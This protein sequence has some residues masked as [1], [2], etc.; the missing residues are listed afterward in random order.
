[1]GLYQLRQE[2]G[3]NK[4]LTIFRKSVKVIMS[5]EEILSLKPRRGIDI[6]FTPI[7]TNSNIYIAT[8]SGTDLNPS[9]PLEEC[10]LGDL[11]EI[12]AD[13][14][15]VY[16]DRVREPKE[17]KKIPEFARSVKMDIKDK[18]LQESN[19][20]NS[21]VRKAETEKV[22]SAVTLEGKQ[23]QQQPDQDQEED[24]QVVQEG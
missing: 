10:E 16:S 2:P 23:Q 13:K 7:K 17:L 20:Y 4:K 12:I 15:K 21:L 5:K 24:F 19:K 14:L 9:N 18:R 6:V 3:V 8:I 22:K 1:L 11:D